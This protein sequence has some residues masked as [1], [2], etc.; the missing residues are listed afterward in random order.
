MSSEGHPEQS[1]PISARYRA[2]IG[3]LYEDT[4]L[5]RT[6]ARL[7]GAPIQESTR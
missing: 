2:L 7:T 6:P 5:K 4:A 3:G 1:P